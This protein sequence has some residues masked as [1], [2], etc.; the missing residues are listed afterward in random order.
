LVL[1]AALPTFLISRPDKADRSF[2]QENL[3]DALRKGADK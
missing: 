1:I 2:I 3:Q